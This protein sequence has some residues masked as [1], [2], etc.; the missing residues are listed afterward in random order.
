MSV[1]PVSV[2]AIV[3]MPAGTETGYEE[4]SMS[5][6]Y[7]SPEKPDPQSTQPPPIHSQDLNSDSKP[8]PYQHPPLHPPPITAHPPT[9]RL[10]SPPTSSPGPQTPRLPSS[11]T[12]PGHTNRE[13]GGYAAGTD[14]AP[15]FPAPRDL[16]PQPTHLFSAAKSAT[17]SPPS[18]RSPRRRRR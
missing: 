11:P 3:C 5:R 1:G 8:P 13:R 12:Q 16:D 18:T 6:N 2:R 4:R 17:S 9:H 7:V 10:S 15:L 14:P